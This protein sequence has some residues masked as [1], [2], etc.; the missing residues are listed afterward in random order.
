M[1]SLSARPSPLDAASWILLVLALGSVAYLA[2]LHFSF[3]KHEAIQIDELHFASCAARGLTAGQFPVAGCHDNKGP[4]IYAVHQLV[5]YASAPYQLQAVKTV[6][7][8][9]VLMVAGAAAWIAARLAGR[10][11]GMVSA[12]L[13]LLSLAANPSSMA[14]KTETLGMLFCLGSIGLLLHGHARMRAVLGSGF[15]VGLAVMTKQTYAVLG[16][17]L[18]AWLAVAGALDPALRWRRALLQALAWSM[19][20]LLPFL[21]L[22]AIYRWDDRLPEFLSTLFIYPLAY[23]PAQAPS[24]SARWTAAVGTLL[25]QMSAMPLIV[26]LW[27][28]GLLQLPRGRGPAGDR[29]PPGRGLLVACA[30]ALVIGIFAS[31]MVFDYHAVPLQIVLAVSAGVAVSDIAAQLPDRPAQSGRLL[32]GTALLVPALFMAWAVWRHNGPGSLQRAVAPT[33]VPNAVAGEYAYVLGSWPQFYTDN[34]L[35]PASGVMYPWALPGTPPS[36]RHRLPPPGSTAH[37][38]LAWAQQHAA[39]Q[40]QEDFRRTPPRYIAV[41]HVFAGTSDAAQLSG[42]PAIGDYLRAHCV[43]EPLRVTSHWRHETSLFRCTPTL[44]LYP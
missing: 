23:G 29:G 13:V 6:A 5:Q 41:M 42:V 38:L 21:G 18:A 12:A 43:P 7:F 26:T 30:S 36:H 33:L 4:L 24:L 34:R 2:R 1:K 25:S 39:S 15:L 20:A 10:I 37:A 22:L 11:A 27:V 19:T 31:P 16:L 3:W 8:G 32:L 35:F 44:D 17:L 14:L 28:V 40:I 9:L